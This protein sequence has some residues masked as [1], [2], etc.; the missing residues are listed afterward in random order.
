MV[1]GGVGSKIKTSVSVCEAV[2]LVL[3]VSYLFKCEK[4]NAQ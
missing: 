3:V 4:I 2:L 1:V